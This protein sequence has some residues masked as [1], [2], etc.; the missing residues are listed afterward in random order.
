MIAVLDTGLCNV[1]SCLNM[2]RHLGAAPVATADPAVVRD[3][4]HLVLPGVGAFDA[5]MAALHAHDLVDALRV[6]VHERGAALLGICL[7]MQLLARR[8][9]EG[10]RPGLGW[11]DADVERLP[12]QPGLRVPHM[13]WNTVVPAAPSP[14]FDAAGAPPEFYFVHTYHVVADDPADVTGIATHGIAFHAAVG[15]GRVQGVQF[16]PEKSHRHGLALLG[17]WLEAA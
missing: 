14:L 13:G 8:S 10:E 15:R 1:G 9:A 12:A 11:L 17:R 16:H 5:G 2:L 4:T 7:G 6:A 3:A